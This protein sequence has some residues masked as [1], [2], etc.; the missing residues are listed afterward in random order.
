MESFSMG[1]THYMGSSSQTTPG[2][3]FCSCVWFLSVKNDSHTDVSPWSSL[4]AR[5]FW[6]NFQAHVIVKPMQWECVPV[7]GSADEGIIPEDRGTLSTTSVS[8][9]P[10]FPSISTSV[11]NR[12]HYDIMTE[13]LYDVTRI[14]NKNNENWEQQIAYRE[15][16]RNACFYNKYQYTIWEDLGMIWYSAMPNIISYQVFDIIISLGA[17]YKHTKNTLVR[18]MGMFIMLTRLIGISSAFSAE[19][20]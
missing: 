8:L 6:M 16:L 4:L 5:Y 20:W 3:L 1:S 7:D 15:Q 10:M 11:R 18:E 19:R 13:N 14:H 2:A 12:Y 17:T 9:G